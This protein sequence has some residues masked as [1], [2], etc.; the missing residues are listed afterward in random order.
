M[1]M[2]ALAWLLVFVYYPLWG[3]HMAFVDYKLGRS[4]FEQTFVGLYY[5]KQLFADFRFHNAFR[6]TLIMSVL[7]LTICSFIMPILFALVLNEVKLLKFKKFVQ[8]VSYLPH[9]VSWVVVSGI[10]IQSLSPSS[11][12][13]NELLV[14][15]GIL[16]DPINFLGF[17]KYFYGIITISSLWKSMGWN[18][19][20][21]IAAITA[22]DP[23]LYESAVVDGATRLHKIFHITLPS[24]MPT[25]IIMF[26][27]SISGLVG[28][29][30]GYEA[31]MLLRN[32]LTAGRA[33]VLYPYS[34]SYGINMLRFS[35]GT[36][37][38]IFTS[39]ISVSLMLIANFCFKR[40]SDLSLF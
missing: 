37:V 31:Q 17:E 10:V 36:A 16:S 39:V 13:I 9:F 20:I 4:F 15:T 19:I 5:F 33:E 7:N 23:E 18:S 34:L 2:P 32:N 12:I 40:F 35:F 26:I 14:K 38:G 6:N 29:A 28:G 27:I 21:Y 22:V 1:I 24:I 8:S 11:G 3:W 30:A 25:I